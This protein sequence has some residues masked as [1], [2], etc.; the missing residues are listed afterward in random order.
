MP[1]IKG[2]TPAPDVCNKRICTNNGDLVPLLKALEDEFNKP[3][4]GDAV[5]TIG[6]VNITGWLVTL[7]VVES[8]SCGTGQ[9]CPGAPTAGPY[10]VLRYTK[11]IITEFDLSGDKGIRVVGLNNPTQRSFTFQCYDQNTGALVTKTTSRLV[12]GI[13]CVDCG[14]GLFLSTHAQLVK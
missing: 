14:N 7:P 5:N 11:A 8:N 4:K 13:D 6:G 3:G 9:T 1:Y 12:T 2:E 10:R